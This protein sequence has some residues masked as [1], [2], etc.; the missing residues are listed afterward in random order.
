M[1]NEREKVVLA[2]V[3]DCPN[4]GGKVEVRSGLHS[5]TAVC[6]HCDSVIDQ[7]DERLA[8]LQ[9]SAKA[10]GHHNFCIPLG[11]KGKLFGEKWQVIGHLGRTET[12]DRFHWREYLLFNPWRGFRWLVEFDGKWSFMEPLRLA[13]RGPR[14]HVEALSVRYKC[15]ERYKAEVDYVQGEFYWRVQTGDRSRVADYES[16]GNTT[17]SFESADNEIHWTRGRN[18]TRDRVA[19]RFNV[20]VWDMPDEA[21]SGGDWDSNGSSGDDSD[22]TLGTAIVWAIIIVFFIIIV[23][24]ESGGGGGGY[25]YSG[26]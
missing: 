11:R 26:K 20:Q 9:R 6:T 17:L 25:Y 12:N 7:T 4:C 10:S 15:T 24:D 3:F 21:G 23:M 22:F 14:D 1:V 5:V 19:E 18:V 8:I 13:V 16:N 2:R